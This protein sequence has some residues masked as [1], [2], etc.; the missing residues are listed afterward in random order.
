MNH[1]IIYRYN[2]P[3][4]GLPALG[5]QRDAGLTSLSRHEFVR[6]SKPEEEFGPTAVS[7]SLAKKEHTNHCDTIRAHDTA[8]RNSLIFEA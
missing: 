3:S 2:V 5:P 6:P 8:Q 1:L 4:A 7:Q